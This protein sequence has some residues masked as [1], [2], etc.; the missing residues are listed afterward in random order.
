MANTLKTT[1]L[2]NVPYSAPGGPNEV[3]LEV[4]FPLASSSTAYTA[5]GDYV[6]ISSAD[7]L[8]PS[9]LGTAG[10]YTDV[11]IAVEPIM[12]NIS[13]GFSAVDVRWVPGT[14]L[15]NGKLQLVLAG[16]PG[17]HLHF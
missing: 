3:M 5:G 17:G 7:Q 10:P 2:Q 8:D 1:L 12:Q 13:G 16:G 6:D 9:L 11:P 14:T 4:N 15:T